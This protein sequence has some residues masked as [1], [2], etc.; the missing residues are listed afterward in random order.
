MV[1]FR[2]F[3]FL[4]LLALAACK[5]SPDAPSELVV[6]AEWPKMQDSI[7]DIFDHYKQ[8]IPLD[9]LTEEARYGVVKN[10]NWGVVDEQNRL[11]FPFEFDTIVSNETSI[12]L[13]SLGSYKIYD[14]ERTLLGSI[15]S[16]LLQP[17]FENFYVTEKNKKKTLVNPNGMLLLDHRF[18]DISG[19]KD[20]SYFLAKAAESWEAFDLAGNPID[21]NLRAQEAL[22]W[23]NEYKVL[24]KSYGPLKIGM[25][26][27]Q[28]EKAIGWQLKEMYVDEDCKIYSLGDD[29]LN[30]Q[31]MFNLENG[32]SFSL[33]RIYIFAPGITTKS[34]VGK[35]SPGELVT[36]VYGDKILPVE[37]IYDEND[38]NLYFVP[39]DRR[40]KNYR[41]NF[42][43]RNG[44]IESFSLG[45]L[46]SIRFIEGCF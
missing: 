2:I 1:N 37:S 24:L 31:L 10:G 45:R 34:G 33:E 11:Y 15:Q 14:K 20:A 40:D 16:D 18:K 13:K 17:I 9:I 32:S 38:S 44:V 29:F 36:K 12:A 39:S 5:S 3:F 42:L 41:L 46:P 7:D 27:E 43:R 4:V 19:P 21:S 8:V 26:K 35:G 30:V 6:E 22:R 28:V 25:S 23:L